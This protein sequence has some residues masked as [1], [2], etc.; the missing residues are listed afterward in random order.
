MANNLNID[1]ELAPCP[2]CGAPARHLE[3]EIGIY[4]ERAICD[5]C[6]IYMD[7]EA[8]N[9]R[10]TSSEPASACTRNC[11][12]ETPYGP[13]T[14]GRCMGLDGP[15][16]VQ[17]DAS[18]RQA[19]DAPKP[20]QARMTEHYEQG[21]VTCRPADHF[22]SEEIAEWRARGRQAGDA[23]DA[24]RWRY[25]MKHCYIGIHTIDEVNA[26]I[27]RAIAAMATSAKEE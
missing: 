26:D 18:A 1:S 12:I 7:P 9:R 21:S 25:W 2:F 11:P 10:A 20:W 5:A 23:L 14:C 19:G 8:W 6:H 24:A 22:M 16:S 13:A 17:G 15:A 3:A 27:D 4:P